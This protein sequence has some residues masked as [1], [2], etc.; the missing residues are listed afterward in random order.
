M[1]THTHLQYADHCR[2]YARY[3][4][5]CQAVRQWRAS[6]VILR[7]DLDLDGQ[8]QHHEWSPADAERLAQTLAQALEE[9][10]RIIWH[11]FPYCR[12]CGG[13]CCADR[14]GENNEAEFTDEVSLL[15]L[16]LLDRPAVTL[17]PAIAAAATDCIYRTPQ[18]CLWPPVGRPLSCALFYCPGAAGRGL[19]MPSPAEYA[20]LVDTLA[21]AQTARL[22]STPV[23][24]MLA[25][26]AAVAVDNEDDGPFWDPE[27]V[28]WGWQAALRGFLA[29]LGQRFPPAAGSDSVG[30]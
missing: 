21:A 2:R 18:G 12:R 5:L 10:N 23:G 6:G 26:L 16:A 22:R 24:E 14:S 8:V 17:P 1:Q 20:V 29:A 4:R 11:D 27:A 30:M 7:V 9:H 19:P 15:L 13:S 28:A 3:E 25:F